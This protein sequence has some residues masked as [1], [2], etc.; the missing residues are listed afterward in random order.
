V[1]AEI[2][3]QVGADF[4]IGI[5]LNSADFQKGGFTEEESMDTIRALAQAGIDLVEISGGT[6][7][8][9]VMTGATGEQK[10][11]TQLR[12]AYF[13]EFAEKA[14]AAVSTPL[15]V[16][17]GFRSCAGMNAAL[18]S[19]ALDLVGLS[20]L[21][22]VDPD[23]PAALLRGADSPQ[24]VRPITTGIKAV[25]RM[26]IMEVAWYARQLKRIASGGKPRP[27]ESGLKAFLGTIVHS[28][29]GTF[30][31]RRLRAN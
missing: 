20:R 12:E 2:R 29:W 15:M 23:A 24:R 6:Y 17:G 7:E 14:R 1:Y 19:G 30:R 10:A 16:T 11:S 25:D 4:P 9:P 22:A 18:R 21:L 27:N 26:T 5:K 31:T 13:L 3:R 8:S 28:G